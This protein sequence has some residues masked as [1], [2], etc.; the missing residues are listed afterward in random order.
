MNMEYFSIYLVL[1]WYLSSEFCSFP[2][3]GLVKY[4]VRFIH[5]YF[6]WEDANINGNM[7]LI[8]FHLYI[9]SI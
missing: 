8:S 6:I 1:L 2:Y 4:F 7:F 9:A 5:K 3:R